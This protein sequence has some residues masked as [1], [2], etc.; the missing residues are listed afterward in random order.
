MTSH[1]ELRFILFPAIACAAMFAVAT[2]AGPSFAEGPLSSPFDSLMHE[3][4]PD[5][6]GSAVSRLHNPVNPDL[7]AAPTPGPMATGSGLR[8]LSAVSEAENLAEN[9]WDFTNPD[10][11][12]GFASTPYPVL[13]NPEIAD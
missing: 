7:A 13:S 8:A 1:P 6:N 12:P 2:S 5:A 11:I 10:S 9:A 4:L 3:V